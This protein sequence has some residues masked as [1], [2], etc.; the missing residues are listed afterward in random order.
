[1]IKGTKK[2]SIIEKKNEK[3]KKCEKQKFPKI[4]N[5]M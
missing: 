1:M 4:Q 2:F 3:C 5:C